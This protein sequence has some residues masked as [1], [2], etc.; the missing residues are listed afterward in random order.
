MAVYP[1]GFDTGGGRNLSSL[2]NFKTNGVVPNVAVVSVGS[3]GSLTGKVVTPGVSGSAHVAVDVFGW[4]SK[5]SYSGAEAGARL[6]AVT[7]DRLLDT[8]RSAPVGAGQSISLTARG[9]DSITGATDVVPNSPT[10]TAVLV[11]LTAVNNRADSRDTFVSATPQATPAGSSPT[12][13]NTNVDAGRI[14]ASLA[15]V[16]VGADGKIHLYNHSGSVDLLVDILGYL[17]T[18]YDATSRVGRIVPLEAPFRAFDTRVAEFGSAPLGSGSVE[19]W[20]FKDFAESVTLNGVC[21]GAQSAIIGNLTAA[22]LRQL[23][24]YGSAVAS[25]YLTMFPSDEPLPGTS[26]VNMVENE[27]VPNTSL[28]QFGSNN[29]GD[30]Y[31][32]TAYNNYGSLHYLLDVF[33]IVLA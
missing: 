23:P 4:V 17:E 14:K 19:E 28:L 12:T 30:D 3:G 24:G 6:I 22:E 16:P 11:N 29:S 9:A 18:G 20:S 15:I 33:A 1:K 21:V 13:S 26:N 2:I 27:A 31:V 7:P 32:V 5:S 8:R 25:S 10:V